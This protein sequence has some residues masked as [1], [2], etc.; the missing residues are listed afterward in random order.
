MTASAILAQ[1]HELGVMVRPN[2]DVLRLRPAAA[3][4][5]DLLTGV[6]AHKAELL[7]LVAANDTPPV[8]PAASPDQADFAAEGAPAAIEPVPLDLL[9]ERE[10]E[11]TALLA[12]GLAHRITDAE[13]AAAY[14]A[15]EARRRLVQVRRDRQAAGLLMQGWRSARGARKDAAR[16]AV[17]G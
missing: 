8:L 2:G 5:P 6:K 16:P 15:A 11:L 7:A 17:C 4:P 14:F 1:L 10:T 12:A 13:K 3:V 9:T